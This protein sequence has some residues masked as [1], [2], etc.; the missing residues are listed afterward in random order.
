MQM[1]QMSHPQ[2]KPEPEQKIAVER[3]EKSIRIQENV[4]SKPTP[5]SETKEKP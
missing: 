5:S 3:P 1:S 2:K 4:N